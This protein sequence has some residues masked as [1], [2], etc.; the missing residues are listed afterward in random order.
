MR[1]TYAISLREAVNL[2]AMNRKVLDINY[3]EHK[4]TGLLVSKHSAVLEQNLSNLTQTGVNDSVN[5]VRVAA[6]L[7]LKF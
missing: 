6:H 3:Y 1:D 5:L 7:A 2:H 4:Y